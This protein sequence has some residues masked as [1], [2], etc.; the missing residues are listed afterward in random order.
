M[1][2]DE[3]IGLVIMG[4]GVVMWP[5]Q[6][7]CRRD[8]A[9]FIVRI[10]TPH[11]NTLCEKHQIVFNFIGLTIGRRLAVEISRRDIKN[12]KT[13]EHVLDSNVRAVTIKAEEISSDTVTKD[14][15]HMQ[16]IGLLA[17]VLRILNFD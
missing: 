5:L 6:A 7:L 15:A 16:V 13:V 12:N 10:K 17:S 9:R 11:L 4:F 3:T 8:E 1:P 2:L 14:F